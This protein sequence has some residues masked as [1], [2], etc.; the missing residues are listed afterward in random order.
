MENNQQYINNY[1]STLI[2]EDTTITS[3]YDTYA[4]GNSLQQLLDFMNTESTTIFS[5]GIPTIDELLG[6][7]LAPSTISVFGG[8]CG[9]GKT[10]LMLQ[11]AFHLSKTYEKDV[12]F[13]AGEMSYLQLQAKLLSLLSYQ[14]VTEQ[15]LNIEPLSF[16]EIF[17][18]KLRAKLS[19][20]RVDLLIKA[21]MKLQENKHLFIRPMVGHTSVEEIKKAIEFHIEK[22]S[23]TPIIIMDYL[24]NIREKN[25]KDEKQTID[26]SMYMF[27]SIAHDYDT[28]VVLL[29]SLGR[30]AYEKPTIG[31][32]KGSG[33]IEYG[34]S[35]VI[36][37]TAAEKTAMPAV[38]SSR[39]SSRNRPQNPAGKKV[40]LTL[41]KS[42]FGETDKTS[43]L[44]FM[45]KYNVFTEN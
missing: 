37:L 30:S 17:H 4:V 11:I 32:V 2:K 14:I 7:G 36:L 42:R 15:N 35:N 23:N 29:S 6:G 9:L 1:L 19:S 24:Q 16:D 5:T 33:E 45:G 21:T 39:A 3:E 43:Q 22:T 25:S 40:L 20:E 13:I 8:L 38:T 12:L 10:T 44:N 28:P 26:N 41:A 18:K 31:A 27:N 34:A